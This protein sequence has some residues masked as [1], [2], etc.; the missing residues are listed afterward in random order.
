MKRIEKGKE[1]KV[2]VK[3]KGGNDKQKWRRRKKGRNEEGRE[4]SWK[5]RM[6]HLI[7]DGRVE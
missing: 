5:L 1:R 4:S 3:K 7:L 2:T 6:R